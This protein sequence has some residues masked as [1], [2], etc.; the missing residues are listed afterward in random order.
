MAFDRNNKESEFYLQG[1]SPLVGTTAKTDGPVMVAD[2]DRVI[3]AA[4]N[5][6]AMGAAVNI[7]WIRAVHY[8]T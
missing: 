8:Y 6:Q 2:D 1:I 3:G 5:G 7:C 4:A